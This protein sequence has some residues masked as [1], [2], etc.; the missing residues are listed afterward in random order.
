MVTVEVE[1]DVEEVDMVTVEVDVLVEELVVAIVDV[2]ELDDV[3]DVA[4]AQI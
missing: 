2:L 1:L 3:D 4:Q